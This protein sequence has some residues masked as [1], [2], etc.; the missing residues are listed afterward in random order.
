MFF[1]K[2]GDFFPKK[3][4][5]NMWLKILIFLQLREMSHQKMGWFQ[6]VPKNIEGCF[7]FLAFVPS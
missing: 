5:G 2:F 3:K 6:H 7:N 4:T 1:L